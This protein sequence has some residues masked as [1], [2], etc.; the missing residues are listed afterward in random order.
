MEERLRRY[1]AHLLA[2]AKESQQLQDEAQRE[3][4]AQFLPDS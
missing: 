3:D 2:K 1:E 4:K